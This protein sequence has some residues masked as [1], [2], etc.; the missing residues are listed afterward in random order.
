[1]ASCVLICR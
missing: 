1:M